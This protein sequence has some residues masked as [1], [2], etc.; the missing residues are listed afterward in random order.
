MTDSRQASVPERRG[1]RLRTLMESLAR[2]KPVSTAALWA[3]LTFPPLFASPAELTSTSIWW[4]LAGVALLLPAIAFRNRY[5]PLSWCVSTVLALINAWF[6][7]AMFA[8]SY[9]IGRRNVRGR[10]AQVTLAVSL[11]A[12]ALVGTGIR[13]GQLTAVLNNAPLLVCAVTAGLAGRHR[14]QRRELELAGWQ[15]AQNLEREQVLAADRVRIRERARIAQ[16]MHDQLGH[17]LTL[18][19]MQAGALEINPKLDASARASAGD[20]RLSSARAIERLSDIIGVLRVDGGQDVAGRPREDVLSTVD[21]ARKA[22]MLVELRPVGLDATSPPMVEETVQRVVQEALTNAAKHAPGAEV[23]VHLERWTDRTSVT[24][25]NE[26]PDCPPGDSSGTGMGL[27]G[28]A[29]RVRVL[30]GSL[31]T[32]GRKDGGFEVTARLPHSGPAHGTEPAPPAGHVEAPVSLG[33][34]QQ[35][36][37]RV[38]RSLVTAV[39]VPALATV[40]VGVLMVSYS[41]RNLD[42]MTLD[43]E[44]Y[45][46]LRNGQT[47]ERLRDQ[48]P[49]QQVRVGADTEQP[50]KPARASCTFYRAESSGYFSLRSEVYRL[51]FTD[52]KL[53]AKALLRED[54]D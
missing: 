15:H 45:D 40:A 36:Q 42:R 43:A 35:A 4:R 13:A 21:R 26:A 7:P 49:S 8:M 19:A 50:P 14:Y 51:C 20:L 3:A 29:E 30:G 10:P 31:I 32:H 2:R 9:L 38:R 46:G 28:L 6:S 11:V 27:V 37:R 17:D 5:L 33:A 48:L 39:A 41:S 22:G 23:R 47:W 18:I 24:V 34:R 16:D 1:D 53:V 25:T 12:L 54:A 44:T 52:G